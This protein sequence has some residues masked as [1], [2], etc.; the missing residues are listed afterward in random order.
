MLAPPIVRRNDH[1][2]EPRTR[3][4]LWITGGARKTVAQ[5]LSQKPQPESSWND[6]PAMEGIETEIALL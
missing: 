6:C 5:P 4:S 1:I 2:D 3:I